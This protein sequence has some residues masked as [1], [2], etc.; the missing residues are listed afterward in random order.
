MIFSSFVFLFFFLLITIGLYYIF[1]RKAGNFILV[2]TSLVFYAWGEPIYV[3]IMIFSILFNWI[4]GLL[5][6]KAKKGAS[7]DN[8]NAK[9]KILLIICCI[10]NFGALSFFKYTNFLIENVNS[11]F[12]LSI[13][14]TEI[15][16]PIGIS[17][18]TFQTLSYVIDVYRGNAATQKNLIDF[19]AFVTMF[20]QLI[21][22]PIVRYI[23]IDK[24]LKT[25]THS[26]EKM[27][28]GIIRFIVGL[29]KK[30]LLANKAGTIWDAVLEN[31]NGEMT[32]SMAWLG[33]VAFTFQ[34]YFDFSGYSD[35]AVGLG[36]MFGFDFPE[37]FNY[38][39]ISKSITEFWRRWHITLGSWFREYVYI[40]LGG[41]RKGKGRQIINLFIVW[42]LTGLWHGASW[43][44][45]IWGIYFFVLLVIEKLFLLD[46]LKKAPQVISRIY[47][48][49]FII[50]GW[51]IFSCTTFSDITAYLKS[52]FSGSLTSD[53]SGYLLRTNIIFLLIMLIASTPIP[54]LLAQKTAS[55][56]KLS[57]EARFICK[58]LACSVVF[59]LSVAYLTGDSYNPFLY[60][61]F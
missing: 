16:L 61:R 5:M 46:L 31:L 13:E 7:S 26:F 22:G 15:A 14:V 52:M 27:S 1:P 42:A 54:K 38:P 53:F 21:A 56:L 6:E 41:N 8:H 12:D 35:M 23:D 49:F 45:V 55:K 25:R 17:F 58:V 19:A 40:P 29:G 39:Y 28:M 3:T 33:A 47:S 36:K 18:Y 44:F 57:S 48:L 37:N 32:V 30:V 60:T 24:Q 43:N 50:I 20:P 51:I 11:V 4:I 34:I 10:A 2:I 59:I 9:E